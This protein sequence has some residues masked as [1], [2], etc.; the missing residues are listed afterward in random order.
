MY[1][2]LETEC[3]A[4]RARSGLAFG[5]RSCSDKYKRRPQDKYVAGREV[6]HR[7]W[8]A[9]RQVVKLL[10]IDA[11][12]SRRAKGSDD[13]RYRCENP[14]MDWDWGRD[15]CLAAVRRGGLPVPPKSS[16]F[17]CPASTRTEVLELSTAHPDLVRRALAME[18]AVGSAAVAITRK[19][20]HAATAVGRVAAKCRDSARVRAVVRVLTAGVTAAALVRTGVARKFLIAADRVRSAVGEW[21]AAA[22]P[23]V[24][25]AR[26]L[27]A[28][29]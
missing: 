10:G 13:P 15:E 18:E 5:W 17:F 25:A 3:R 16:C 1:G 11:G 19:A 6:A 22:S 27:P 29:G 21:V 20:A 4:L 14:L 24:R 8:A 2:T 9:G 23:W 28:A 7:A 12:E 26:S